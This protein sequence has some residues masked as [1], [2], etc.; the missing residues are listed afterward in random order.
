MRD[1]KKM[2]DKNRDITQLR[3]G[4]L[5]TIFFMGMLSFLS[6]GFAFYTQVISIAGNVSLSPQGDFRITNVLRTY[7]EN[8]DSGLPNF[9]D[10]TV[11]FNL[12]FVKSNDPD[13]V[14]H[15]TYDII[16]TNDT[17]YDRTI[18]DLGLTF[19][20]NDEHGDPLGTINYTVT[21]VDSGGSVPKLS[22]ATAT[23][24]IFF[25]PLVDQQSYEVG[26][27]AE[28][29][30][31]EKPEGNLL[32]TL[33]NNTGNIK[34]GNIASFQVQVMSTYENS[35]TFSIEV[36]SDKVEIC[37]S[38]GNPLSDYTISGNN[39]GQ[40]FQ[41][42]IKAKSGATFPDDTLTTNILIK[43]SGLPNVSAGTVTLDVDKTVV[44]VDTTPPIISNV[45]ATIQD[46]VGEVYLT[47]NGEDDYSGVSKYYIAVCDG[48]GTILN[49]IDTGSDNTSYTVT[50]LSQGAVA[51]TY[52]FK[53][54]GVDLTTPPNQAS[55]NDISNAT[56]ASGYCSAT[57]SASY[58]WVYKVT[59]NISN[60]TYSGPTEVNRNSALSNGRI[61]ANS[62]YT[63]PNSI[64]VSMGGQNITSGY[65]YNSNNGNFS[66]TQVTG[67]VTITASCNF[68]WCLAEGTQILLANGKTKN[69]EDVRY[70][71]LLAVWSYDTGEVDYEYPIWIEKKNKAQEYQ[72]NTFSD[73]S[74][75]KTIG[76]HGVFS[77]DDYSF[78]SVDD[79]D[80]FKVGTRIYKVENNQL[81]EVVVTSIQKKHEN[82]NYYHVV[83]SRYYNV[84]AND[85]LTTDGTVILSN[86]YGFASNVTWPNLKDQLLQDK[87]HLYSYSELQDVLPHYM[88]I[89]MRAEE[90]KIL[91]N[92][93]FTL[94]KFKGY[95]S[96]NQSREGKY[97]EV[98]QTSDGK[99]LFMVTTSLDSVTDFNYSK[100]LKEE[101]SI[102][103][104][105]MNLR[106]KCYLSSIDKKCYP[107]GSQVRVLAP[108]HFKAIEK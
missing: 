106:I 20:V 38:S 85:F 107:G 62:N 105:P 47:W 4:I 10:D 22:T 72:L 66:M 23:V 24:D 78:V 1:I 68:N 33:L 35:V 77:V 5:V 59:A 69:I 75:L 43:S 15:A 71:D 56:T 103:T 104:L 7:A 101:N 79:P 87:N 44:Y 3:F 64:T 84:I 19:T 8:T 57:A 21:G 49:T 92:Y 52:I 102:Y 97:L 99:N 26:G 100:Y 32:A 48:S 80:H 76:Y 31:N 60:G 65:T 12:T 67:D 18:S 50:G 2:M 93:G 36:V 63:L 54:Y 90:G 6:V 73:G 74:T 37:D 86:L 16:F 89:G 83:S 17:F 14:Y 41:F 70:T 82:V 91:Q 55:S 88:F 81:K 46:T 98:D 25:T 61:S 51:S 95:L 9:T 53:V 96:M 94:E 108:T 40:N 34:N 39:S 58:Q 30:S 13:P 42:Y 27:G 29:E 11:D 45:S 28:V